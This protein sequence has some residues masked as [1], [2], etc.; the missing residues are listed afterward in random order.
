MRSIKQASKPSWR[1][2]ELKWPHFARLIA[3]LKR[4]ILGPRRT[5]H[6]Y[7]VF[8]KHMNEC[9]PFRNSSNTKTKRW[10]KLRPNTKPWPTVS[11]NRCKPSTKTLLANSTVIERSKAQQS[12]TSVQKFRPSTYSQ[13]CTFSLDV[14]G[15]EKG[16]VRSSPGTRSHWKT[17]LSSLTFF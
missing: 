10:N 1:G 7:C 3:L 12:P 9:A 11:R 8:T 17:I 6:P 2:I 15:K 14:V 4:M 16:L 13:V 5:P